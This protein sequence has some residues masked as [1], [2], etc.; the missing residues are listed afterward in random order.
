MI[1]RDVED[2]WGACRSLGRD[3][4]EDISRGREARS[5]GAKMRPVRGGR[6]DRPLEP[7]E[8]GGPRRV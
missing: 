8:G 2:V 1:A 4:H 7:G 3:V 5:F 6:E